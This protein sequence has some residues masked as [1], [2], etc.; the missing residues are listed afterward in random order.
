MRP[1]DPQKE[2]SIR[3]AALRVIATEGLENLSMQRLAQAAG[4]SPRTIYLKFEN[5]E[6]ML[7][8]LFIDAALPQYEA[9]VLEGFDIGMSFE[10]GVAALWMNAFRFLRDHE[11]EFRL[12]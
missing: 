4:V 6:D 11:P 7:V 8:R 10:A 9:A 1:A 12:K 2:L 3:T 5:K